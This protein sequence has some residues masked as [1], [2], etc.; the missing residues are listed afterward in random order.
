MSLSTVK[1]MLENFKGLKSYW[2]FSFDY[3]VSK[4]QIYKMYTIYIWKLRKY[5]FK[6]H[7]SKKA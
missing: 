1:T 7:E 5:A 4:L 2:A 6:N 3:N